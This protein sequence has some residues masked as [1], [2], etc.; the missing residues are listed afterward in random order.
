MAFVSAFSSVAVAAAE[1][2]AAGAEVAAGAAGASPPPPFKN[3][4]SSFIIASL[5]LSPSSEVS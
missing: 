3:W 5:S 4:L 1:A 2:V